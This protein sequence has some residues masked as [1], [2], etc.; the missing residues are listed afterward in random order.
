MKQLR[1]LIA[2]ERSARPLL[3]AHLQS[4]LGTGAAYV[5]LLVIA[6]ERFHSPLAV[7]TI[8]LC[9]F[10][11]A[12]MLGAVLGA[13]ADR[14]SRKTILICADVLRAGAFIG[15]ALVDSFAATVALAALAGVGQ[16]AFGP[17]VMASIPSLVSEQR[18]GAATAVYGAIG[19]FGYTV[20]PLLGA[21]AFALI[22]ASGVLLVN[23]ITFGIS[24]ALLATLTITRVAQEP[25]VR[26]PPLLSSARDGARA[27]RRNRAAWTVV[28]S[29]TFFVCFFGAM[30]VAEVILVNTTLDG[31]AA[32]Y[33][34]T[35]AAMGLGVT[36][37]AL[38]AARGE[39]P[40]IGRR[41][42]LGGIAIV[43]VG[44]AACALAPV[45]AVAVGAFFVI[46]IGNGIALTSENVLLQQLIPDEIKGRVF[47]LKGAM[48]SGAF[49]VSYCG[50]GLLVAAVGTR[51]TFGVIAIGSLVVCLTARTMLATDRRAAL[52]AVPA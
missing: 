36:G 39:S 38:L 50:G 8:L 43:G 25:G 14:W 32:A 23:G 16:A 13:A 33:A 52:T 41:L 10:L 12:L 3:A 35:T 15:L 48:I 20:G 21:G 6:Y 18:L 42:Y 40:E 31:G 45:L 27:L 30:N 2:H 19:E 47:G 24:A 44:M 34:I 17:A 9:E 5:A 46:G 7:S 22:G 51:A 1:E 26:K 29:S 4:S 11:P 28:V 49:L 37:G